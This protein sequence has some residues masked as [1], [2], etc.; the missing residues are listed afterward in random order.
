[1]QMAFSSLLL[2]LFLSL[3]ASADT[4]Q[5]LAFGDQLAGGRI[6]VS[7]GDG[8]VISQV[9]MATPGRTGNAGQLGLY[10]FNVMG[11]T[12]GAIW[13]LANLNPNQAITM[14]EFNLAGTI[15]LFDD[16]SNPSTPESDI[17]RAG[18]TRVQGP[19]EVLSVEFNPWPNPQNL[20]DMFLGERITWN[21]GV[22]A[23]NTTFQWRDDTDVIVPEP[24]TIFLLGSGLAGIAIK[25]RKRLKRGNSGQRSQ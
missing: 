17:G 15:S 18:V 10:S 21:P 3:P 13:T 9:I 23:P 24:A 2:L 20:G 5:T 14:V 11:E 16:N 8:T 6:T 25:V 1:M 4:I 12:F 7:F 22:F 19:V